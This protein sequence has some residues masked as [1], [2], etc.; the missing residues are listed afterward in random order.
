M[1][2]RY[3]INCPSTLQPGN[4]WHGMV[5][6][7]RCV[8]MADDSRAVTVVVLGKDTPCVSMHIPKQWLSK[9]TGD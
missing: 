5:V 3:F 6:A 8:E 7:A 9:W 4:K 1:Y 2:T